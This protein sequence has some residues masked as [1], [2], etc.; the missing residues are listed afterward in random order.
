MRNNKIEA[1]K[2]KAKGKKNN[3]FFI[4][5][6]AFLFEVYTYKEAFSSL[7]RKKKE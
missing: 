7:F 6:E 4:I 3:I 5:K 1:L 2:N